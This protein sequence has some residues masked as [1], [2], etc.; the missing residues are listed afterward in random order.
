MILSFLLSFSDILSAAAWTTTTPTITFTTKTGMNYHRYAFTLIS[1]SSQ[2]C[3]NMIP[4]AFHAKYRPNRKCAIPSSSSLQSTPNPTTSVTSN[5]NRM[6]IATELP[7]SLSDSAIR[8]AEATMLYVEQNR[9]DIMIPRGRIDFDT[10]IGD[11]TFSILQT[12]TEFMQQYVTA[13]CYAMIP[14]LQT[15]RQQEMMTVLQAKQNLKELEQNKKDN[16]ITEEVRNQLEDEY[17]D[18]INR[19][20]RSIQPWEGYQARI[21][22]PDEG[23]AAY[24]KQNWLATNLVPNCCQ[25]SSCSGIPV[26]NIS[27]DVLLFF[28]CPTA[29]E[30]DNVEKIM[31]R[32]EMETLEASSS[33]PSASTSSIPR[34]IIFVN[35]KL[36]DM[37]VTGFGLSGRM[38]R[39]RLLDTLMNLYYLRTLA[40]GAL[41][42]QYPN[43]YSVYQ[44]DANVNGGYRLIETL[45]YLPSNPEVEDIYDM[46]NGI[47]DKP[48]SGGILDQFGD[49][50]QGMMRL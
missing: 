15:Q 4:H 16:N 22:F 40:W 48:K 19:D 25:F 41:T 28:Y 45:S 39:E 33:S 38:L 17:I 13:M 21:Y 12:S 36:V 26:P 49:F 7:D 8:A 32:Y 34:A 11:E 29:S 31:Q 20:G 6:M 5:N 18:I 9:N 47:R 50:V 23:S 46:A 30:S 24:A 37:G 27:R 14:N 42:R 43:Q 44:E 1:S 2:S 10:N 3:D 35:P